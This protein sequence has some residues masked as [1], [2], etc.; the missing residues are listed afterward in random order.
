MNTDEHRY[1]QLTERI[2]ACAYA[3]S[4]EL[5]CGFLENVYE[6]AMVHEL[7]KQGLSA[8]QQVRFAVMYDGV[9]V[10]LYVADLVVE[11]LVLVELKAVKSLDEVH[12]AQCINLLRSTNLA[13]C[14][15]INFAKPKVEIKRFVGPRTSTT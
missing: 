7:G 1:V 10:G 5:G 6:N 15:L 3:V 11:G 14:L 8:Q 2:I 4:N 12:S 9:E 13:V